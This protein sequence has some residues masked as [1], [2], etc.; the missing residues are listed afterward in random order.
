MSKIGGYLIRSRHC[1]SFLNTWVYPWF[2]WEFFYG[3]RVSHFFRFLCCIVLFHL[4][5]TCSWCSQCYQCFWIVHSWLP[6]IFSLMRGW[7]HKRVIW[8]RKSM[9]RQHKPKEKDKSNDLQSTTQKTEN[10]ITRTP[11]KTGSEL[12]KVSSSRSAIGTRHFTLVTNPVIS[13]E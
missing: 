5:S 4:S 2:L 1:L 8:I 13:L 12:Q 3:F 7:R 10:R 6:L 9:D 11:L